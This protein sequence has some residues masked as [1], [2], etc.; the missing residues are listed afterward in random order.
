MNVS[1]V[2]AGRKRN[3]IGEYIAKYFHENGARITGVLGTTETSSAEAASGLRKYGIE[4]HPY[5]DF[6][7]MVDQEHPDLVVIA[8]P[9][10]T[11]YDYLAQCVEASIHVFC[12]KPFVSCETED[13]EKRVEGLL[14]KAR[15]KGL[16]VAMNSQWPF[17]MP[18]YEELCGTIRIQGAK[19]FLM[20]MSPSCRG[21]EMIPES[22]PHALSLLYSTFG[23]GTAGKA[24][25]ES[26]GES[27][28]RLTFR[29][30]TRTTDCDVCVQLRLQESQPR[31]FSFGFNDRIVHRHL[32]LPDYAIFFHYEDRKIR[33]LDPLTLSVRN[34][35]EAVEKKIE[36]RIGPS[37]ILS[38]VSCLRGLY[39]GYCRQEEERVWKN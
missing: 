4:A 18:Y 10:S 21:R 22:V 30:V 9:S 1:I 37:H 26:T 31:N 28:I 38:N 25:F 24:N 14:R 16:M 15:E 17:A 13:A 33:I 12:E 3:G 2:G 27:E 7:Q 35:M 29:Y 6:T 20:N 32:E 11:H 8:S 39:E 23:A 36:P 19:R 34:A 5:T